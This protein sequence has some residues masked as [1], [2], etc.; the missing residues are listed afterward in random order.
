MLEA[1]THLSEILDE[2]QRG[3]GFLI[4][5]RGK[6]VAQLCPGEKPRARR[7][8]GFAKGLF[9]NVAPDFNVPLNDFA[10]FR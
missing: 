3:S 7:R 9:V 1:K 4:T 2:V 5:K 8:A 10:D 6:P